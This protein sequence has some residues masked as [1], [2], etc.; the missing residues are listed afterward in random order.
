MV[1]KAKLVV[2]KA[3]VASGL[4]RILS[5]SMSIDDEKGENFVNFITDI[6]EY[7]VK[8]VKNNN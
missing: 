4:F 2:S 6:I 5:T 8:T 7:N 1:L 3:N